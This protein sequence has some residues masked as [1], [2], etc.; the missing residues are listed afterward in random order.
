MAYMSF[1]PLSNAPDPVKYT[2]DD[3]AREI[4]QKDVIPAM[5]EVANKL[6]RRGERSTIPEVYETTSKMLDIWQEAFDMLHK[7][8]RDE[9]PAIGPTDRRVRDAWRW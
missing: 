4:F 5:A 8:V 1:G 7:R 3:R 9:F 6:K 2:K